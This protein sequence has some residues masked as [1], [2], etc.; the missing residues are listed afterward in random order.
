MMHSSRQTRRKEK[1]KAAMAG[2]SFTGRVQYRKKKFDRRMKTF[3]TINKI[4]G[5]LL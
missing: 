4:L 5:K 1:E 3:K 2:L